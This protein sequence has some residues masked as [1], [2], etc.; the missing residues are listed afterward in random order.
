MVDNSPI[1]SRNRTQLA[2]EEKKGP[3]IFCSIC[4]PRKKGLCGDAER[5][6]RE[7]HGGEQKGPLRNRSA[8][9]RRERK[10]E[11]GKKEFWGKALVGKKRVGKDACGSDRGRVNWSYRE[12]RKKRVSLVCR[13]IGLF[14][15]EGKLIR[16]VGQRRMLLRSPNAA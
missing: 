7:Q 15:R 16:R 9:G 1:R 11:G 10:E 12:K 5:S 13:E 6:R 14:L 8:S 3:R 4:G 2:R